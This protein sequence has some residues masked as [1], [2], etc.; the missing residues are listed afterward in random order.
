MSKKQGFNPYLP[1]YEYIPDGEPHVFGNRVYIYGSHD[2]FGGDKFCMND[3]ICYS[4]DVKNLEDWR[5][6]GVIYARTADP[7]NTAGEYYLW[8]PDV[9][10]GP[11][12]KYYLYYCL[13][14]EPQLRVAVCDTPAGTYQYLGVVRYKDGTPLGER[15]GDY[16]QFDPGVFIDEDGTIYVYS[17]MGYSLMD[18]HLVW[19]RDPIKY[20]HVLTLESD[21]LTVKTEPKRLLPSILESEGTGFEGHEFFEA[22]SVKKINGLYY[23]LYSSKE[24][25]ELC[26]CVSEKPDEGF[27]YGG[28]VIALG[29]VFFEGRERE[30]ALNFWGNIHGGMECID[31][32]WYIFYHRH[33]NRTQYSRQACAEKIKILPD[34]TIPQVEMTSCG[35]NGGPLAGNGTYEARIACNLLGKKGTT[36][37]RIADQTEEYPYFT[38][39]EDDYIPNTENNH[40][41]QQYIAN[42]SDGAVAGYKYFDLKDVNEILIKV[43]AHD[44]KDVKGSMLISDT[45]R[46]NVYGCV[47]IELTGSENGIWKE[48]RATIKMPDKIGALYMEYM[49]EGTIDFQEFTL[50]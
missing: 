9:T 13:N 22:S 30:E 14:H 33:T 35:L 38:Q 17:G 10:Q 31:G 23:F 11:D 39:D 41:P 20:S 29:D 15:E 12:G 36:A 24:S 40:A 19:D 21:M 32:E 37:S 42:M 45:L 2:R 25:L 48:F 26:Y 34:G 6:E 28:T 3:Y 49:G 46:G 4:A 5:Y 1:A 16:K 18:R 47:P 43:R 27:R 8:A 44:E 7:D 50:I